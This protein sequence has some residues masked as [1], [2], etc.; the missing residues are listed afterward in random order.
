MS[1]K[2]SSPSAPPA[3]SYPSTVIIGGNRYEVCQCC[4]LPKK[5]AG[6]ELRR[7]DK[8]TAR[9]L[10][11]AGYKI[12]AWRRAHLFS[13]AGA[14]DER[15]GQGSLFGEEVEPSKKLVGRLSFFRRLSISKGS[16]AAFAEDVF[17]AELVES[18][19]GAASVASPPYAATQHDAFVGVEEADARR[20]HA[21]TRGVSNAEHITPIDVRVRKSYGTTPG[22][23][24]NLRD[25]A[26]P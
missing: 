24:G 11:A 16:A 4:G 23:I 9:L 18:S 21:R 2:T 25:E 7:L 5:R 22:Q 14:E 10:R 12:R 15:H 1:K 8:L 26:T 19:E 3:T 6:G 17:F 13:E 20:D